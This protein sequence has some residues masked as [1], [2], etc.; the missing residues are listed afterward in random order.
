MSSPHSMKHMYFTELSRAPGQIDFSDQKLAQP[1]DE[2]FKPQSDVPYSTVGDL[3][4]SQ[5]KK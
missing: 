2:N 3:T 4:L 5:P 1:D